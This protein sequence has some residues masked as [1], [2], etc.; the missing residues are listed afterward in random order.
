[1]SKRK[2][3]KFFDD[4]NNLEWKIAYVS[5]KEEI[6]IF[7][8]SIILWNDR[9]DGDDNFRRMKERIKQLD[10]ESKLL[11]EAYK[12]WKLEFKKK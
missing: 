6:K 9:Y 2:I 3:N 7:K 11:K 12:K 8:D 10:R 4:E 1:M 5:D